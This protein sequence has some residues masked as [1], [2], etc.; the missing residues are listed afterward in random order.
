[1][2][3]GV[4]GRMALRRSRLARQES[5]TVVQSHGRN[6]VELSITTRAF[7]FAAGSVELTHE[8]GGKSSLTSW[9]RGR[10]RMSSPTPS[11]S[12]TT[13]LWSPNGHRQ[14]HLYDFW[15]TLDGATAKRRLGLR[16]LDWCLSKRTSRDRPFLQVPGEWRQHLH[17]RL[18]LDTRR[19]AAETVSAPASVRDPARRA[20]GP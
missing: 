1:M 10:A 4:Y 17:V 18:E 5:V 8:I 12:T 7:A 16:Q 9:R 2:P 14:Q 11:P 3:T 6:T 20:P 19:R 13:R 15:T